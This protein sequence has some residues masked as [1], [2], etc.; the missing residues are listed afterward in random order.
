MLLQPLHLC[1]LRHKLWVQSRKL[2]LFA[3]GCWH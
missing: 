1:L 2:H 3:S